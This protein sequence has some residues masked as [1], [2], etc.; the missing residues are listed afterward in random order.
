VSAPAL[1]LLPEDRISLNERAAL[2]RALAGG[3]AAW[4]AVASSGGAVDIELLDE[5]PFVPA[6]TP[7][8]GE[9]ARLEPGPEGIRLV[10]H[11][12]RSVI[13]PPRRRAV[14]WRSVSE[15]YPLEITL[16]SLLCVLLPGVGGLP[17]HAAGLVHGRRGLV[18]FGPSGAGKSTLAASAPGGVLS[19]ELVVV[20]PRPWRVAA[21]GFWGEHER[22]GGEA[23]EAPLA[24]LCALEKAERFELI[25]LPPAVAAR[26]ILE[27]ITVP[28]I[29]GLWQEAL[30]V[31]GRLVAEIPAYVLRWS[32][33]S[34][35][36]DELATRLSGR[37]T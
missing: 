6:E 33:E 36:W 26:R 18:F 10:H 30:E 11:S 35:P 34:P 9:A 3:A 13:D 8:F 15:A 2:E 25:A 7:P 32:K 5:P 1:R 16:R 27:T 17:L 31:L 19:D 21:S 23:R 24:A 12:F 4:D 14:L 20:L 28:T 22:V 37:E 29:P